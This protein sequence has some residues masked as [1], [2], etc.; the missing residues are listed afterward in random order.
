MRFI[1]LITERQAEYAFRDK[2]TA[3]L[4]TSYNFF[5]HTAHGYMNAVCDDLGMKYVSYLSANADDLIKEEGRDKLVHFAECF[6]DTV[7][8]NIGTIKGY[9]PLRFNNFEYIPGDVEEK[10]DVG[11]NK[12]LLLTDSMDTNTNLY[13]MIEQFKKSFSKEP[14]VVNIH[15]LDIKGGCLGCISCWYD[16]QCIYGDEYMNFFNTKLTEAD[17]IIYAGNIQGRYLSSKWKQFVDRFFFN[18]HRPSLTGKQFGTLVS[19]PASQVSMLSEINEFSAEFTRSNLVGHISDECGDSRE[20]DLLLH[21]FAQRLIF[22]ANKNYVRSP[23]FLGVGGMK[24]MRDGTWGRWRYMFQGDHKYYKQ[25]GMYDFPQKDYKA[26]I[27]NLI[28]IPLTKIPA[29][30]KEFTKMIKP[31]MIMA[32]KRILE[33]K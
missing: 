11:S 16:Y 33:T 18:H 1:E 2:Y 8:K 29:F 25:H 28:M 31:G 23:T 3:V 12:I 4:T 20:L 27:L 6:F 21:S 13:R 14:E 17:I 9:H 22:F 24:I 10:I 32:H 26:R 30:R 15:E 19:G 7:E 5:D